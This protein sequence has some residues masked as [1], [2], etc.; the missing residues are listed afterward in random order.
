MQPEKTASLL[1]LRPPIRKNP[2]LSKHNPPKPKNNNRISPKTS[3]HKSKTTILPVLSSSTSRTNYQTNYQ[4]QNN[5]IRQNNIHL[6]K[7]TRNLRQKCHATNMSYSS[8]HKNNR[9]SIDSPSLNRNSSY[10]RNDSR[11]HSNNS[12]PRDLNNPETKSFSE[13]MI[14]QKLADQR[15]LIYAMNEIMTNYG[16][17][18]F[19]RI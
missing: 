11:S 10:A 7:N 13:L 8:H 16:R 5:D 14:K 9:F 2:L 3:H 1:P 18:K 6:P 17:E 4:A 19:Q 12:N 15:K